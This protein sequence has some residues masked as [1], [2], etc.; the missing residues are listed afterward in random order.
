MST[1]PTTP[2]LLIDDADGPG[3]TTATLVASLA[4]R[5]GVLHLIS[6]A[7]AIGS[8]T[9]G[10][11]KLGRQVSQTARGAR[12]REAIEAGRPGTNGEALWKALSIDKWISSMAPS[13]VLEQM[14]ND[15]A[16]LLSPDLEEILQ[17]LPIPSQSVGLKHAP[18]IEPATFVDCLLGLW[19]F[20]SELVLAVELLAAPTFVRDDITAGESLEPPSSNSILR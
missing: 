16:L 19:A 8:L 6:G 11:A 7:D 3:R 4:A 13:P 20:S 2:F 1:A 10:F 12:L 17:L 9:A 18:P 5:L 14:R 15:V